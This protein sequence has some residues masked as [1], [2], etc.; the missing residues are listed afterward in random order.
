MSSI[1]V[2]VPCYK[3]GRFLAQCVSSVLAQRGPSVRVLVIDDAS[4]DDTFEV[5]TALARD[6]SRVVVRRHSTN[7][8]HIATYNEGIA[9][10]EADYM[11]LLSADD[12]LLPGALA[13]ACDLLDRHPE[14][15]FVFGRAFGGRPTGLHGEARLAGKRRTEDDVEILSG[16]RFL[17]VSGCRAIVPTPTAVVRMS[18]QR[19]LGGYRSDLPHTGDME[20]WYR[21]AAHGA[22][23]VLGAFQAVYRLHGANMSHTY[24]T[25]YRLPD[26]RHRQAAIETFFS[27][28][29]KRMRRAA[30]LRN[31]MIRSLAK[32]ATGFASAAFND[33]DLQACDELSAYALTLTPAVRFSAPWMKLECKR[34]LGLRRWRAVA[35]VVKRLRFAMSALRAGDFVIGIERESPAGVAIP[36]HLQALAPGASSID[37][38]G[39]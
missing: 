20:M 17:E 28:D 24:F 32:D 35:P 27:N 36:S 29:G 25:T 5:A 34:R 38:D 23:G 21:F 12:Y 6:D 30:A 39:R 13:R 15:G 3:Y 9:W 31:G 10:A 7:Q 33:G 1:D 16:E 2:V 14:V 26:L 37:K 19:R 22:V 11:L 18:L 4:P 8:G